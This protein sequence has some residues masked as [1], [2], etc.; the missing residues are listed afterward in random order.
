MRKAKRLWGLWLLD[1]HSTR[2]ILIFG[3]FISSAVFVGALFLPAI[4]LTFAI[5]AAM[6]LIPSTQHMSFDRWQRIQL[7]MPIHRQDMID[8]R[9]LNCLGTML[10]TVIVM[11][12]LI[13]LISIIHPNPCENIRVLKFS[14]IP[15]VLSLAVLPSYKL[16]MDFGRVTRYASKRKRLAV[17]TLPNLITVFFPLIII[18]WGQRLLDVTPESIGVILFAIA[19]TVFITSYAISKKLFA[20][21][22]V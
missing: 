18:L 11:C 20:K 10:F 19:L 21:V 12:V 3:L 8:I 17:W 16:A 6:L 4:S 1:F 13:V 5:I 9:F 22:D 15:L 2:G 14:D 7:S